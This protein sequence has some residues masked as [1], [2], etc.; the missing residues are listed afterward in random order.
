MVRVRAASLLFACA[1]ASVTWSPAHASCGNDMCVLDPRGP[2]AAIG[3]WSVELAYSFIDQDDVR[4]G[5][6]P[7]TVGA[8]PSEHNE[9]ETRSDVWT[10]TARMIASPRL[11]FAL[12]LPFVK[13]Y[14]AHEE[15]HHVGFY[16]V[17]EWN[18][19]GF[20]DAL[21]SAFVSP[22]GVFEGDTWSGALM[23]GIKAP[24][25]KDEVEAI[26]GHQPE[27][28]AR[29]GTGSWDALVGF[30]VRRALVTRTF[31]GEAIP[32]PLSFG[33]TGRVNGTGTEDY[34]IGNEVV[35]NLS[36]GWA[37][38]SNVT[39]LAQVNSRFRAKDEAAGTTE[40]NTGGSSWYATPGIRVGSGPVGFYGYW[41]LRL[42]ENVNGIQITAPSH[43]MAGVNYSL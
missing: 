18:Y 14:H 2:E 40:E 10:T 11:S 1:L 36:S 22:G 42:Y 16:E 34:K 26:E 23:L 25:G 12:A 20:G 3:R 5:T 21:L 30:Q 35:A 17:Q 24:T 13:R 7:A 32:M 19:E 4:V 33:I 37:L 41:Q 6:D 15:E 28:M 27:P 31:A 8:I 38:A 43:F 9:I 39:F 29:P